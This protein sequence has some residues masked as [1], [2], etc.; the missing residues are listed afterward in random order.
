MYHDSILTTRQTIKKWKNNEDSN[1]AMVI[2][3]P[4]ILQKITEN[5][6]YWDSI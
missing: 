3:Q 5:Q 4:S 1:N 2:R 6:V